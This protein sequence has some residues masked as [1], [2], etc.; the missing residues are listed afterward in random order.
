M[1][2]PA[3]S[4][5]LEIVTTASAAMT[6]DTAST[7]GMPAA[8]RAPNTTSSNTSVIGIEVASAWRK[9]RELSIA[10]VMLASPASATSRSG[11]RACTAATARW[12]AAAA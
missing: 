4:Q 7:I 8:T 12:S 11:W 10:R 6:A 9:F 5:W 1:E 2:F 3:G